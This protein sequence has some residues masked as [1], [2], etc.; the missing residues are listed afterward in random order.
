MDQ[1]GEKKDQDK[2]ISQAIISD[3]KE[4]KE[5]LTK[6]GNGGFAWGIRQMLFGGPSPKQAQDHTIQP[7][8]EDGHS[9]TG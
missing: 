1:H 9:R 4:A 2:A 7:G 8:K 3:F 6:T 5:E